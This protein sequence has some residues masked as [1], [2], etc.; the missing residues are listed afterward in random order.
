MKIFTCPLIRSFTGNPSEEE[1]CAFVMFLFP[2]DERVGVV[3]VDNVV[4][5]VDISVVVISS[6]SE[7]PSKLFCKASLALNSS[8][9]LSNF[10]NSMSQIAGQTDNR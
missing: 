10:F 4:V 3:A 2:I 6:K 7:S 5:V 8:K 9:R 1:F